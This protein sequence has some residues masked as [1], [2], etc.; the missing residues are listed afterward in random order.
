MENISV[1]I[2]E[3]EFI[4]NVVMATLSTEFSL[5]AVA[6]KNVGIQPLLWRRA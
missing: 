1:V 3:D 6:D 4:L 2:R 5:S